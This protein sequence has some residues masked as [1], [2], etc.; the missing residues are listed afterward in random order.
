MDDNE[1]P[2]IHWNTPLQNLVLDRQR[3]LEGELLRLLQTLKDV[4]GHAVKFGGQFP[5]LHEQIERDT[6][7]LPEIEKTLQLYDRLA[8]RPWDRTKGW[9]SLAAF[10]ISIIALAARFVGHAG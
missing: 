9:L 1:R 8:Q 3:E 2:L 10:A 6:A 5:H 7:R 4:R